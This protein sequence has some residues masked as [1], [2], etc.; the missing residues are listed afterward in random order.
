MVDV[1]QQM[2][3]CSDGEQRG[4]RYAGCKFRLLDLEG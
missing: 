2:K 1:S 4:Y 3:S